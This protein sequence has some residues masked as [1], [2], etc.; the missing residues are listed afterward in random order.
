VNDRTNHT[1]RVYFAYLLCSCRFKA[2]VGGHV[3]HEWW[4]LGL[5]QTDCECNSVL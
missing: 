4:W 2:E 5:V 1:R 3:W